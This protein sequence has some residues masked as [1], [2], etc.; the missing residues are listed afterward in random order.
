MMGVF[1]VAHSLPVITHPSKIGSFYICRVFEN[2]N[3]TDDHCC[4]I[5]FEVNPPPRTPSNRKFD[6]LSV[7]KLSFFWSQLTFGSLCSKKQAFP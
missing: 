4:R 1:I 6:F 3:E 5:H 7:Q 2:V